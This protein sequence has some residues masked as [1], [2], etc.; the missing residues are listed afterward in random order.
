MPAT[1][2]TELLPD[3]STWMPA[4]GGESGAI[5]LR[6]AGGGRYAKIVPPSAAA[7]LSDERDR[8]EWLSGTGIPGPEVL[9]W[10]ETEHGA[11]LITSTVEGVP[12]DRLDPG[13]LARAWPSIADALVGLHG[14]PVDSC[15]YGRT[16]DDMMV[17]ARATVAEDRV[18]SEFLPRHLVGTPPAVILE[19]L[20]RELPLRMAQEASESVICHGDLCLPNV[21]VDPSTSRVAGLIDLG[22]LGRADPC[23]DIALLLA[24]ACETWPDARATERADRAFAARYGIVLDEARLDFYLR[25]D[26]L[27]W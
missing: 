25:L 8:I 7:A 2:P 19:D 3:A 24:N 9:D 20:E 13:G 21:L 1:S 22:R 17:L 12:A 4:T 23:A 16:L 26:P 6:D 10:R 11:C 18:R 27:T 5:V 15:P 14:I